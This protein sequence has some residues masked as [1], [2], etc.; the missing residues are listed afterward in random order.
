MSQKSN[1]K[2]YGFSGGELL[3]HDLECA[4]LITGLTI[5]DAAALGDVVTCLC[6]RLDDVT[7]SIRDGKGGI[8]IA[9]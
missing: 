4:I 1:P 2:I 7:E 9:S 8:I 6:K 5:A 3:G